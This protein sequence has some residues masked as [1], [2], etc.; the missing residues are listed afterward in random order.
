[1]N[2][3]RWMSVS[4][5]TM[6]AACGG[7]TAG[8]VIPAEEVP[9]ISS[10][11]GAKEMHSFSVSGSGFD[12]HNGQILHLV[13]LED[14]VAKVRGQVTL[15]GSGFAFGWHDV[16]QKGKVYAISY[17]ADKSANGACDAA[18]TDHVW[19]ADVALADADVEMEVEHNPNFAP[20]CADFPPGT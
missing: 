8:Y 13:L 16:L 17:Y 11:I 20:V 18:P 15:Q 14:G 7:M 9:E 1:M 4:A 5:L 6:T 12:N 3:L 19:H 2:A 10:A